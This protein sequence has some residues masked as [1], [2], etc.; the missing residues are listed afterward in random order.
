MQVCIHTRKWTRLNANDQREPGDNPKYLQVYQQAYCLT[1][2]EKKLQTILEHLSF[3]SIPLSFSSPAK[4]GY[5]SYNERA[6]LRVSK[7][8]ATHLLQ[9]TNLQTRVLF[10]RSDSSLP[11]GVRSSCSRQCH[12]TSLHTGFFSK[13]NLPSLSLHFTKSLPPEMMSAHSLL[14]PEPHS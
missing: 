1:S 3:T 4:P 12:S 14:F 11:S 13:T 7:R 2:G 9:N 10:W 5:L 6:G 8:L